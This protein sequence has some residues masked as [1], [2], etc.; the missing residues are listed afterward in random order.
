FPFLEYSGLEHIIKRVKLTDKFLLWV[1]EFNPDVIYIQPS[2]RAN[3]KFCDL[4]S[5]NFK[6]PVILHM[7]DDWPSSAADRGFFN[8]YWQKTI[9]AE[10]KELIGHCSVLMS[11]SQ[12]MATEYYRRYG[13]KFI[14][15][16][17]PINIPFWSRF[18]KINYSL[19]ESPT[20]LYAGRTGLGIQTSLETIA[21]AIECIN[22]KSS[23]SIKLVLSTDE[24][25]PWARNYSCV[26][27]RSY[28]SYDLVPKT[29]SEADFLVLPY[30]FSAKSIKFIKYSMPTKCPEYM[31]SGT[32]ILLFAP[33]E[34]EIV[35][36]CQLNLC[37][38]IV[39][40]NNEKK[41]I[42]AIESLLNNKTE[43]ELIAGNAKRAAKEHHDAI[44]VTEAFRNVINSLL[45][46]STL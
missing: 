35:R 31:I 11:I 22:S 15:F 10:L 9:D 13:E 6:V 23:M 43:R 7:M 38:K 1:K 12:S 14:V 45:V 39:T 27:L 18:Q 17:N 24:D 46:D 44:N 28:T 25:Q 41:I 4:V 5:K 8:K 36:Y 40:E 42:E 20:F 3:L 34:T 2:S 16:H 37:A 30:D 26:E 19:P 32:P 29:F 33:P 21:K